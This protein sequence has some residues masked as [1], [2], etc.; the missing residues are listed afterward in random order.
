MKVL[1][2]K[3]SKKCVFSIAMFDYRWISRLWYPKPPAT[4]PTGQ[5]W[6]P[7]ACKVRRSQIGTGGLGSVRLKMSPRHKI[8]Q[9]PGKSGFKRQLLPA[10]RFCNAVLSRNPSKKT[11]NSIILSEIVPGGRAAKAAAGTGSGR[12]PQDEGSKGHATATGYGSNL[13][14]SGFKQWLY[15]WFFNQLNWWYQNL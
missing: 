13:G 3:S 15:W 8:L 6:K 7:H 9:I 2:G 4:F 10:F 5:A 1:I 12:S 14:S 11:R